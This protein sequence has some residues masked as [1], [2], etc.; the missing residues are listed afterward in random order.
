VDL[1]FYPGR[2][3]DPPEPMKEFLAP[4]NSG[5]GAEFVHRLGSAGRLVVDP[6]GQS[7]LLALDMA[8][9][10]A[11]VLVASPNPIVRAW[12]HLLAEPPSP[13]ILR[14]V[15]SRL[16]ES[17]AAPAGG[18]GRPTE[19]MEAHIRSLYAG[20]CAFCGKEA[21]AGGFL[22][23]RMESAREFTPASDSPRRRPARTEASPETGREEAPSE[24]TPGFLPF[25]LQ[26]T[27]DA[28]LVKR[29]CRCTHCGHSVEEPALPADDDLIRPFATHPVQY[30]LAL[31]RLA[32]PGDPDRVHAEEAMGVYPPRALY[33]L[34]TI[35][36]RLETL[37]LDPEER[38]SA[39]LLMLAALD[40]AHILRGHGRSVRLRP[41]SLQPPP[42]YREENVWRL[43]EETAEA[44]SRPPRSVPCAR[45][46]PGEKP[47][48]GA[49]SVF[50]GGARELAQHLDAI[51]PAAVISFFPRPNQA[52]WTLSAMWAGWLWGRSSAAALGPVLRRRRYDWT[53]HAQAIRASAAAL[54]AHLPAETP[55]LGMLGESEPEFLAAAVWSMHQSGFVLQSR[56]LRSDTD[57]AQMLWNAPGAGRP[58]VPHGPAGCEPTFEVARL[59]SRQLISFRAEPVPWELLHA[60]AWTEAAARRIIPTA[61]G[62]DKDTAF[63]QC[64]TA[65]R[66]AIQKD[67]T[68]Q[69]TTR[70]E[71][72][73]GQ[74]WWLPGDDLVAN[75]LMDLVEMEAAR[76]LLKEGPLAAEDLDSRICA[77]FPGLQT[78]EERLV[79]ACLASYGREMG[80]GPVFGLRLEDYPAE[81]E[82]ELGIV[83]TG[84]L[85]LGDQLGFRVSEE[86]AICW[87]DAFGHRTHCFL[88]IATGMIGRH[89]LNP[90]YDPKTSWI[91]LPGGRSPLVEYKIKRNVRLHR[92]VQAGWRF[93]KFR[94][95]RNLMG[96]RQLA[97]DN[98]NDWLKLDPLKAAED[99]LPFF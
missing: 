69:S 93:L 32:P 78:P 23:E 3:P 19:T 25:P 45:W 81:R 76:I 98:I 49:V 77:F 26:E 8:R 39:D 5:V 75:P 67:P 18:T 11:A 33:A 83:R 30:H 14:R 10:G 90:A 61:S 27:G 31:E 85:T 47:E 58:G 4:C 70:K 42:E 36:I 34:F 21:E 91:V 41:R 43:L 96:E 28:R 56:A 68:I 50:A 66:N 87:A 65:V 48:A 40:R 13:A 6:F 57:T 52:A 73:A 86:K 15:L 2:K 94:H 60:A 12:I 64:Q 84:L 89:L 16:A 95:L 92:A 71:S 88:P 97:P 80:E 24:E 62:E 46:H 82:V 44:W 20:T 74:F 79:R 22:W 55:F 35:L 38:R 17:T 51:P 59:A 7:P 63:S 99:E 72:E 54:A 37:N 9:A 53:W 1:I 29:E